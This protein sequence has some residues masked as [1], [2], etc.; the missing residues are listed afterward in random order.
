MAKYSFT[1]TL[2]DGQE[3]TDT[4]I[5]NKE[6][7]TEEDVIGAFVDKGLIEAE[8]MLNISEVQLN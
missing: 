6:N 3:V 4:I 2:N 1:I 7:Y 5:L 8:N